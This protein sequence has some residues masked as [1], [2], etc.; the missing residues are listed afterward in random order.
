MRESYSGMGGI[1]YGILIP[2]SGDDQS[3]TYVYLQDAH[4]QRIIDWCD[5]TQGL[6]AAFDFTTKGIL[7]EAILRGE[8][9]RLRDNEVG[10]DVKVVAAYKDHPSSPC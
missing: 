1:L 5:A 2:H 10:I 9:W 7:Q 8:Y 3:L 6:C 4:R